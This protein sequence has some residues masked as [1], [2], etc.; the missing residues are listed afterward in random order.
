MS[1]IFS[2][3]DP[4]KKLLTKSQNNEQGLDYLTKTENIHAGLSPSVVIL[5]GYRKQCRTQGYSHQSIAGKSKLILYN[6][7]KKSRSKPHFI[8]ADKMPEWNH[9]N[10]SKIKRNGME[11]K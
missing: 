11:I 4:D 5:L 6:V 3:I 2:V 7:K 9:L 8:R 1:S 10:M